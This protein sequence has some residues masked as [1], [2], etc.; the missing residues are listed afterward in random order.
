MQVSSPYVLEL[1]LSVYNI[2]VIV[3]LV[4]LVFETVSVIV[5]VV[6]QSICSLMPVLN[7][8][9]RIGRIERERTMQ[10]TSH[11]CF[12]YVMHPCVV[13][14]CVLLVAVVLGVLFCGVVVMVVLILVVV[15]VVVQGVL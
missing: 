5:G 12:R 8:S 11:L 6:F 15:V 10:A 14:W 13:G 9:R 7:Q 2:L 3:L 1:R 4:C